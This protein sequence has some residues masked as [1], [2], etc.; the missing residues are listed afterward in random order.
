MK[1]SSSPSTC[2]FFI[3]MG[4]MSFWL[5][6]I[7][8]SYVKTKQ[9]SR[10]GKGCESKRGQVEENRHQIGK[11]KSSGDNK[12]RKEHN[13]TLQSTMWQCIIQLFFCLAEYR[14]LNTCT[15]HDYVF[16]LC[17]LVYILISQNKYE[18]L[19]EEKLQTWIKVFA[20]ILN[21]IDHK[22]VTVLKIV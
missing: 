6:Q 22:S 12:K 18:R 1:S 16:H 2:S 13:Q 5:Q 21:D 11:N 17:R 19:E 14:M 7:S 8:I 9:G 3:L 4:C 10:K 20:A 15:C